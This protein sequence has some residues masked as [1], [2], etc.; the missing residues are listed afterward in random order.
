M[1]T[2]NVLQLIGENC[3]RKSQIAI[4]YCYRFKGRHSGSFVFWID[5]GTRAGFI[6]GYR[7][8]ADSAKI[9]GRD[10]AGADILQLVCTWLRRQQGNKW[11]LV[12][13]NADYSVAFSHGPKEELYVGLGTVND[14]ASPFSKFIP[15]TP[16]GFVLITSR[17]RIVARK[18]TGDI[19]N[20]LTV[21]PMPLND[22]RL[23]LHIQL[24]ADED[25]EDEDQLLETLSRIPLALKQAAAYI[26]RDTPRLTVK[27]YLEELLEGGS[28]QA[29]LLYQ[30]FSDVRRDPNTVKSIGQTWQLVLYHIREMAPSSIRLLSLA[31][32][33]DPDG[34]HE[35]LLMHYDDGQ[36][37]T[38]GY[39]HKREDRFEKNIFILK[40]Y[41]LITTN[42]YT[43]SFV[44]HRLV[45]SW[46][47]LW[48]QRVGE[49]EDWKVKF[50]SILSEAF[51]R[52]PYKNMAKCKTLFPH[53]VLAIDYRPNDVKYLDLYVTVLGNASSYAR[54]MKNY[55]MAETM[56]EKA[57]RC[58]AESPSTGKSLILDRAQHLASILE[59]QSKWKPATDLIQHLYEERIESLG[60]HDPDTLA[61]ATRLSS[62]LV[63]QGKIK[64]SL[65]LMKGVLK[66][67]KLALGPKHPDTLLIMSAVSSA[68]ERMGRMDKALTLQKTVVE[69]LKATVKV[70]HPSMLSAMHQL[71]RILL[72]QHRSEEAERLEGQVFRT[73]QRLLGSEHLDTLSAMAQLAEIMYAQNRSEEAKSLEREVT[74]IREKVLGPDHP[75]TIF[76]K[77]HPAPR[78][79][80][81][82]TSRTVSLVS[83]A[84]LQ[85]PKLPPRPV[86]AREE[87]FAKVDPQTQLAEKRP[88]RQSEPKFKEQQSET[89]ASNTYLTVAPHD[90]TDDLE[91]L[92]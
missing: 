19:I 17:S 42:E 78:D 11:L 48:L 5:A 12:I 13:D 85:A 8:I 33:F 38:S 20:V 74:L 73:R 25:V 30:G 14:S 67:C 22:A 70:E 54:E 31:S 44:M 56:S 21:E 46:L 80:L 6:N 35:D 3:I 16:N 1:P 9:P 7:K 37:A 53:A 68:Y 29:E 90:S 52:D 81:V 87:K 75:D 86:K 83:K 27:K 64:Q 89:E 65:A 79:D 59:V 69:S 61:C 91:L 55:K 60:R 49:L 34:I 71:A 43:G 84:P 15:E 23:L 76:A 28:A 36:T 57:F 18:L 10:D 62:L 82:H 51:P 63:R 77:S 92:V 72:F 41:S 47:K 26:N 32:L 4:E 66:E 40:S 24:A 50:L 39:Q 88:L 2:L 45:Q 58:S